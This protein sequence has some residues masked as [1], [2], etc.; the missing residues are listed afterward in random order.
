MNGLTLQDK[1]LAITRAATD[2]AEFVKLAL[3]HGAV[4]WSLPTI[5]LVTKG[6]KIVDEFLESI[7]KCDPDYTVFMS[8]KAVRLLFDTAKNVSRF[9]ELRFAV[10]NTAVVAVGPKTRDVLWGEY[11]IKVAHMPPVTYSSVGVGELFTR[12]GDTNLN[13]VGS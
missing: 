10:A 7:K 2:S 11:G 9:D 1:N 3:S 4:P 8:S 6:E 13:S 12:L 5:Q